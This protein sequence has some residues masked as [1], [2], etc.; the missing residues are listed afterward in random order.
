MSVAATKSYGSGG[1]V[2]FG[3]LGVSDDESE[4]GF[5]QLIKLRNARLAK[6]ARVKYINGKRYECEPGTVADQRTIAD[7]PSLSSRN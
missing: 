6:N 3:S 7:L 1:Q 2:A 5:L 4:E